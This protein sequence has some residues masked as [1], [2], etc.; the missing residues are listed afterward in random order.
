VLGVSA[1]VTPDRIT[2][3]LGPDASIWIVT[4]DSPHNDIVK[5]QEH[6][7]QFRAMVRPLLDRIKSVHGQNATLHVFP[8]AP[9]SIA[10]EFGRIRMPKADM[11]WQLYDQVNARGGFVPALFI[12][13]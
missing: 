12:S 4:V 3:I 8:A 6:L 7:A 13:P 11:P 1:T 2:S 10:V 5:S 9:V